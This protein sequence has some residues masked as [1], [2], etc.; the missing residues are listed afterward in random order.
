MR[1]R[2]LILAAA[3]L[4]LAVVL[5]VLL[6]N[7]GRGDAAGLDPG[8]DSPENARKTSEVRAATREEASPAVM[9]DLHV[10]IVREDGQQA[11]GMLFWSTSREAP[12][13]CRSCTAALS[14]G[15][16]RLRR[17][18]DWPNP[19]ESSRSARE[20]TGSR[21]E[22]PPCQEPRSRSTCFRPPDS[23]SGGSSTASAP[24]RMP[25]SGRAPGSG[26]MKDCCVPS[27]CGIEAR[28]ACAWPAPWWCR[29]EVFAWSARAWK[30]AGR[31]GPGS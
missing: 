19:A 7:P 18:A 9:A 15:T 5:V 27:C 11:K 30:E 17:S 6:A 8:D 13:A 14:T 23:T 22:R 12:L 31:C 2:I 10:R 28:S 24:R 21:R 4:G 29:L 25:E 3:A 26:P 20:T 1:F 16:L